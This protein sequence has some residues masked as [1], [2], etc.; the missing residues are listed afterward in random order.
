MI[1]HFRVFVERVRL[2]FFFF[3]KFLLYVRGELVMY[4]RDE[5]FDL[6][7]GQFHRRIPD[8]I[9]LNLSHEVCVLGRAFGRLELFFFLDGKAA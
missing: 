6:S 9:G 2:F 8:G 4:C 5:N 1:D 7:T 3:I